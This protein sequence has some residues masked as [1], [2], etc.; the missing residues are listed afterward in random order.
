MSEMRLS[1]L[2]LGDTGR[3]T[4]VVGGWGLHQKLTMM[5]IKE[6]SMI[7]VVKSA[8][9]GG[10]VVIEVERNSIAIGRGMAQKIYVE[11]G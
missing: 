9:S 6:G 2:S 4:R 11:S 5:G 8:S 1:D 7:R 3:I 10:P